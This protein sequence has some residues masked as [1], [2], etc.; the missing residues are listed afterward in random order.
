M[1]LATPNKGHGG[2]GEGEGKTHGC[3]KLRL[4]LLLPWQLLLLPS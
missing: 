4:L 3:E 2:W 1:P